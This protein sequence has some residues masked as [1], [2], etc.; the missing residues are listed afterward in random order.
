MADA[1]GEL[2]TSSGLG[3]DA[4]GHGPVEYTLSKEDHNT[5]RRLT[6]KNNT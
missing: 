6:A 4:G 5:D 1:R 3:S 2:A